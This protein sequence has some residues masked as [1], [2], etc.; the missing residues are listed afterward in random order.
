MSACRVR[1]AEALA[2]ESVLPLQRIRPE[3]Y[4]HLVLVDKQDLERAVAVRA[5]RTLRD[6]A[7]I[8][9]TINRLYSPPHQPTPTPVRIRQ[10]VST[11]SN[12]LAIRTIR[13]R[14]P[15]STA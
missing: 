11:R 1:I 13:G 7:T 9:I 4:S 2:K 8:A 3:A 6:Q 12:P 15:L 10:A 5:R 14:K